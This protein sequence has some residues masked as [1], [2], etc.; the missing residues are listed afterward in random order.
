V[1][2]IEGAD[3][4]F[5]AR[6]AALAELC[7][8]RAVNVQRG[9]ALIVSA[10]L[11]AAALVRHVARCAYARGCRPF[12]CIYEDPVLIREHI[13]ESEI[14]ALDY[15]PAWMYRSLADGLAAGAAWLQ[16]IGPYPDLLT[17]VSADRIMRA[18]GARTRASRPVTELLASTAIQSS[19]VPF[20]TGSWARQVFPHAPETE[21][22]RQLWNAV[23]DAT[24]VVDADPL[25]EWGTHLRDMNARRAAL[26]RNDFRSLRFFDATT[27][28]R[29][30]LVD[31]HQW[32]GG[33]V[34]V[35]RIET[36]PSVPSE[37]IFTALRGDGAHGHVLFSRPL[38]LGGTVVGNLYAEFNHGALTT[39]KADRGLEA[40]AQLIAGDA[41]ARRLGEVGLVP[42]SSRVART[43]ISFWNPLF[44][45]NA[46]SHVAFGQ[47]PAA[48]VGGSAS[49][50]DGSGANQSAMHI[51]CALGHP[52]MQV[53]GV[54][55]S[56]DVV[57][58]MRD[59]AFV[60]PLSV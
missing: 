40:F 51:D 27:D 57:P 8:V 7:V 30:D 44:D 3:P 16:I 11:E 52:T 38:A 21:A 32:V 59:G 10:P 54:T 50:Q 4:D 1:T 23:F 14:D 41:G 49:P 24:R 58:V 55:R 29:V 19:V 20:V 48:G 46:A 37:E 56:G 28:L 5:D 22:R 35:N 34:A 18:H 33:T 36:V 45:R 53:D 17:G 47:S 26:Q 60:E 31:G 43:G 6:L 15:A 42:A 13:V 2:P 39:M 9:Q 25:Q 12:T